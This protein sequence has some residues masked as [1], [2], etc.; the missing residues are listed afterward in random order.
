MEGEAEPPRPRRRPVVL[1]AVLVLLVGT[2]CLV[3]ACGGTD[4]AGATTLVSP[5]RPSSAPTTTTAPPTTPPSPTTTL[6][7]PT[8]PPT[9]APPTMAP[10][11]APPRG[12]TGPAATQA[13][14]LGNPNWALYSIGFG[15]VRPA[16]LSS[17]GDPTGIIDDVTWEDWGGPRATGHGTA[18]DVRGTETVAAAGSYTAEIVAF[19]LGDCEGRPGYRKVTWYFPQFGETFDPT[20]AWD[21]CTPT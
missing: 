3:T 4:H 13:P 16:R 15:T 5:Q 17:G 18:V 6:P 12:P 8:A 7:P 10:A 9:M 21:V 2:A 1:E 14:V 11:P 20:A 19:D